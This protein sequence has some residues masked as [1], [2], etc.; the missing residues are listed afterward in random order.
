VKSKHTDQWRSRDFHGSIEHL[1][2]SL[3]RHWILPSH[4]PTDMIIGAIVHHLILKCIQRLVRY[5]PCSVHYGTQRDHLSEPLASF[6]LI[7]VVEDEYSD[8]WASNWALVGHHHEDALLL[9]GSGIPLLGGSNDSGE[10]RGRKHERSG[11]DMRELEVEIV[12][13]LR[14][15]AKVAAATANAPEEIGIGRSVE[16]QDGAV[17][18]DEGNLI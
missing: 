12:H 2:R 8:D 5:H 18:C 10:E 13:K 14:H 4:R 3:L 1:L 9:A 11:E 15:T 17:G 7:T 16:S 6:F